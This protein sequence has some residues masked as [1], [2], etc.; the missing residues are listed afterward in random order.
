[1]NRVSARLD[2][3]DPGVEALSTHV[4]TQGG[5]MKK[6]LF[7]LVRLALL[8]AAVFTTVHAVAPQ[9]ANAIVA[10]SPGGPCSPGKYICVEDGITCW[11]TFH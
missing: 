2:A 6:R 4:A 9:S 8:A 7:D 5:P 11:G 1:M 10:C 3:R